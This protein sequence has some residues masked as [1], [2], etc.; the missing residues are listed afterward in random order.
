MSELR[1]LEAV[2]RKLESV[3]GKLVAISSDTVK[4]AKGVTTRQKLGYDILSDEKVEV[5]RA[6]GLFFHE[7]TMDKDTTIP[8]HY[9]IDRTGRVAWRWIARKTHDRPDPKDVIAIVEGL[10]KGS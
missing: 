2:S 9:L 10:E 7:S 6:L 3:G 5:I 1:G 4:E 8:A